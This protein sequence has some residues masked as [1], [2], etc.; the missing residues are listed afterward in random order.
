MLIKR[1]MINIENGY[2]VV[3]I[4]V[5]RSSVTLYFCAVHLISA[6]YVTCNAI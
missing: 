5:T 1:N 6:L 4:S 2:T 3:K